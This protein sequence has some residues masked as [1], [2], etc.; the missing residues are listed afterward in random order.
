MLWKDICQNQLL[1]KT[2]LILFLNKVR[3]PVFPL[4]ASSVRL[5]SSASAGRSGGAEGTVFVD[6]R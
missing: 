3:F 4:L 1:S 2:T 5:G 6:V